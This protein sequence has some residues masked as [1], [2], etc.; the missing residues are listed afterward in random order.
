MFYKYTTLDTVEI[1]LNTEKLRW[2]SPLIFNDVSE[3]KNM[4][5]F[6]PSI[7][8]AKPQFIKLLV[9]HVFEINKLD[10]SKLS[11][12]SLIIINLISMLK[13][14]GDS[15]EQI[16]IF[17]SEIPTKDIK[18]ADY[19][20][21]LFSN[22][23]LAS[24]RV[25]C[26]TKDCL[27]DA[28]WAHYA[29]NHSGCVLEFIHLPEYDTSWSEAKEV[30][31][32]NGKRIAGSALDFLLYGDTPE[33][34][35]KTVDLICYTKNEN[36]LYEKEW[37]LLTWRAEEKQDYGDYKFY[38]EELVSITFGVNIS[39]DKQINITKIIR[40]KY[41]HCVQYKALIENGEL[42]REKIF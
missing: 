3:F 14:R 10:A 8:E 9:E 39:N 33:L 40:E 1:I 21:D 12:V 4:P 7:E 16:T 24:A 5:I 25:L 42:N 38:P 37:R 17:M 18:I 27:N 41:P 20:N 31:Y 32:I 11:Q 22:N 15:K 2:S 28:M 36:W 26:V 30:K 13:N 29:S 19:M 34:R 23:K 6:E 35:K